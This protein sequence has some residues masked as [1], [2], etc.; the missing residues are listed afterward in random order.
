[1]TEHSN[2]LG[3]VKGFGVGA[4]A[5]AACAVVPDLLSSHRHSGP[6]N[7][8]VGLRPKAVKFC[9]SAW[10]LCADGAVKARFRIGGIRPG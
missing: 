1:M 8:S 2:G 6:N 4:E 3:N 7:R 10:G 9:H 5:L